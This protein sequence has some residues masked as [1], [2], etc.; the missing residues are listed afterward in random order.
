MMIW[1]NRIAKIKPSMKRKVQLKRRLNAYSLGESLV[2]EA[3]AN[4][5]Y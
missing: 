3:S 2:K 1:Y 4:G 5:L